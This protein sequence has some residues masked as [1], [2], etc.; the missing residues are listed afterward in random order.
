MRFVPVMLSMFLLA[1]CA[2]TTSLSVTTDNGADAACSVWRPVSWSQKD[3]DQTIREVKINNARR[4][5]F[6]GNLAR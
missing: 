4:D 5:G 1:G 3:T 2:S 6:C